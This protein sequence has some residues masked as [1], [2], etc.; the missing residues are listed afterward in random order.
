MACCTQNIASVI[1]GTIIAIQE[2]EG[3]WYL[4]CRK[5]SKKVVKDSEFVDLDDDTTSQ[6]L[7]YADQWRCT[8]CNEV[9]KGIKSMYVAFSHI[10]LKFINLLF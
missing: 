8:K 1:V 9:V 4:G 2:E 10:K 6:S 5:C 3:W 7:S